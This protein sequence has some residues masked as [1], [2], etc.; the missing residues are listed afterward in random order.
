MGS[1]AMASSFLRRTLQPMARPC[2]GSQRALRNRAV[3]AGFAG[4]LSHDLHE[5]PGEAASVG[6]GGGDFVVGDRAARRIWRRRPV[7]SASTRDSR[8]ILVRRRRRPGRDR[9]IAW[10]RLCGPGRRVV[11]GGIRVSGIGVERIDCSSGT[12]CLKS[13]PGGASPAPTRGAASK[14]ASASLAAV[15]CGSR[16]SGSPEFWAG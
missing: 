10:R 8:R 2:S 15:S 12:S 11:A 4:D 9:A 6:F 3:E 1:P 5:A 13:A 7:R 14:R 16:R